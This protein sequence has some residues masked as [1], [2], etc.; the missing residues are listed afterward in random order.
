MTI[1]THSYTHERIYSRFRYD[2]IHALTPLTRTHKHARAHSIRTTN[3]GNTQPQTRTNDTKLV[4]TNTPPHTH[5][6]SYAE[7]ELEGEGVRV[8]VCACGC[9]HGFRANA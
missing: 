4:P 3:F 6:Q 9:V 1:Y 2:C 8:C 5:M 7:E